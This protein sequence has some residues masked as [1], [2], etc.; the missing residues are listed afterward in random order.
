[1]AI[2]AA[3]VKEL[4]DRTGAGMLE[5]RKALEEAGGNVEKAIDILRSRGAAKAATRAG[6]QALEGAIGH[7]VHMNGKI[8]VLVEVNCETDFVAKTEEFQNLVKDLAMHVAAAR[9]DWVR[10]DEVPQSVIEAERRVYEAAARNE[11]KPE[12]VLDR[13]VEGRLEKFFQERCLMEQPF[14]KDPDRRVEQVVQEVAA[15]LG[16]NVTVR[17][18]AR[19]ERGEGLEEPAAAEA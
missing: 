11:G 3:Q 6:R 18:F 8:G 5:C 1:M 14:V 19:F 17:R 13:I 4:R 10:R 9:P 16:E 7:Y 2:S 12:H 15:R